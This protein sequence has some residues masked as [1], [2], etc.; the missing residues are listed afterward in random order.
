MKK[1]STFEKA[2]GLMLLVVWVALAIQPY[3][4]SDWLLENALVLV[5]VPL[6]VRYGSGLPFSSASY[7]CLFLFFVLHLIGAHYTYAQVPWFSSLPG[8]NHY[9]RIVHFFYGLLLAR[10]TLD[11]FRARAPAQGLWAW[12]MPVLF[13]GSH[14]GLYETIEW[15]AAEQFGGELGEAF[16]GTQGDSWDAQKDM[17]LAQLGAIL[18]V[19]AW[20]QVER[21]TAA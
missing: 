14:G 20:Q 9:D 18:G 17:A 10:P 21:R 1:Y 15:F 19:T 16:L 12:V 3:D 8:R 6:I 7:C 2:L 4:R 13:L 5:A 11:L